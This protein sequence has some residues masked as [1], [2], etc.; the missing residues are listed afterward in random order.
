M[1]IVLEEVTTLMIRYVDR[2]WIRSLELKSF[3]IVFWTK[4][5]GTLNEICVCAVLYIN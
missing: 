1:F 4:G 2:L 5:A 3:L